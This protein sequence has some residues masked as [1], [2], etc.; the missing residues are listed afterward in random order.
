M[1]LQ[2]DS[3]REELRRIVES[4]LDLDAHGNRL[5][6]KHVFALNKTLFS[7]TTKGPF[8]NNLS[9][10]RKATRKTTVSNVYIL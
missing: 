4:G 3:I 5:D 6:L 7:A 1:S 10:M 9:N 2:N 8:S